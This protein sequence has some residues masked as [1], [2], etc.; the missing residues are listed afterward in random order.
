MRRNVWIIGFISLVLLGC[1]LAAV[2]QQQKNQETCFS[3]SLHYTAEGMRYWYE[4]DD[5]L[6]SITNVPYNQLSCQNCHVKSC[7]VCHAS[8][9]DQKCSYSVEKAKDMETC[10]TCHARAKATFEVGKNKG[11]LDVHIAAGMVCA[12][13]HKGQ[14]VHGDGT[15]YHSMRDEGAVKAECTT[16]HTPKAEEI[17]PHTVH[18]DKLDCAACHVSN[19][20]SCLNCH[21]ANFAKTGTKEGNFLPPVQDWLLL[22][23]YKGK[24][25]AGSA[26]T[27]VYND[28]KFIAYAPYFTHAIQA[29][30]KDCADCHGNAAM[31]LIQQ[32]Q[33][34][35][36]AEF[37]DGKMVSWQGVV[38][39]VP[40]QLQWS[41][42]D[43][44]GNEWVPIQNDQ[45]TKIQLVG[46]GEPLTE[47]QIKKMG[48]PFK[49]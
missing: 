7:D 15:F 47:E 29:K 31:K 9:Q 17:R 30:A 23:N 49:K 37:K 32:G 38:P 3:K 48:I 14:D 43:K 24:I 40:D 34:V 2:Q 42:L 1:G 36:M 44:V 6:K 35:P 5:G 26:Q 46:Y 20:M 11:C 33:S 10:L 18:R 27:A 16:C 45:P 25:T 22:V 19:S 8:K 21:I 41:F 28:K 13:C 4:K 39:L 12:D